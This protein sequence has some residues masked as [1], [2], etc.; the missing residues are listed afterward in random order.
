MRDY[1]SV[2][3]MLRPQ[4]DDCYVLCEEVAIEDFDEG[5]LVL[6][7][8]HLRLV[9]LNPVAS[10]ILRRLDGRHTAEQ[11]AKALA[12]TYGEPAHLILLDV[13]DLL[14][15]LARQ[16]VVERHGQEVRK[17]GN[18]NIKRFQANPD[19]GCREEGPDGAL[20]FNADTDATLV[21]N[22]TGL[23]IWRALGR[24]RTQDEIVANLLALCDDVPLEQVSADVDE[25]LTKVLLAQGFAGEVSHDGEV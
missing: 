23:L 1:R 24:A 17:G 15:D 9:D 20:L 14:D 4:P 10:A 21:I 25:F 8:E 3:P 6:L 19:V 12:L 22:P 5:S 2:A 11:I 16:G 18:T 7:C 13:L